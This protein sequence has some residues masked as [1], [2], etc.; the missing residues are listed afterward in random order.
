MGFFLFLHQAFSKTLDCPKCFFS[1][2]CVY[3][4][5]ILVLVLREKEGILLKLKLEKTTMI[6]DI[7]KLICYNGESVI[8]LSIRV[9]PD[10]SDKNEATAKCEFNLSNEQNN[11]NVCV[12]ELTSEVIYSIQKVLKKRAF[13]DKD[14]RIMIFS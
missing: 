5:R 2:H 1:N 9:F 3:F 8:K 11:T 13:E 6:N 7:D 12:S 4:Y 14:G 10:K